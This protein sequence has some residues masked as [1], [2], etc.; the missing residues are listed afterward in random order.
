MIIKPSCKIQDL[1]GDAR[2]LMLMLVRNFSRP[3]SKLFGLET[4]EE[5]II[6]LINEGFLRVCS[7]E[8]NFWLEI[9]DMPTQKYRPILK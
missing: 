3:V 8:E 5:A 4:T 6:E 7:D 9:Y 1:N 2:K